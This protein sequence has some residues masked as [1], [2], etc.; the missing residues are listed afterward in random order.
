MS[1]TKKDKDK[2]SKS[3]SKSAKTI[4]SVKVHLPSIRPDEITIQQRLGEGAY[5]EVFKGICRQAPVAV[6]YIKE[7]KY[8]P[9]AL[10]AELTIMFQAT[11]ANIVKI[12]GVLVDDKHRPIGIVT[13]FLE[14]GDLEMLLHPEDG[15]VKQ[16]SL[17]TKIGYAIDICLGMSWLMGKE[18][19]IIHRDLKPAN[20]ML[21]KNQTSC[22]ICDFGLAVTNESKGAKGKPGHVG[23]IKSTR[24]SPL[25]MAPER[26]AI[27]VMGD[28]ELREA[29]AQEVANYTKSVK[30]DKTASN[31]SEK[32][33]VYSFGVMLWEMVTQAW[34][35][36]D[37]L[38][39]ESFTELFSLILSGKRPSLKDIDPA[40]ASIIEKCWQNDPANRPTFDSCIT[41]L[42]GARID[43]ALQS[44]L[45]STAA[46][47]WKKKCGLIDQSVT[48]GRFVDDLDQEGFL[49]SSKKNEQALKP[50]IVE[51]CISCLLGPAGGAP[52]AHDVARNQQISI[53]DFVKLIKWFGPLRGTSTNC[54]HHMV[55]ILQS[56]WFFGTIERQTAERLIHESPGVFLIRLNTG[57]NAAIESS[58]FVISTQLKKEAFHIRVVAPPRPAYGKWFCSGPPPENKKFNAD[59][60]TALI[61]DLTAA[62]IL[63]T[64]V[65]KSPFAPIFGGAQAVGGCYSA[66]LHD[67]GSGF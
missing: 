53:F 17:D 26:V 54:F 9:D 64:P 28:E 49:K 35:F 33:D 10:V 38:T 61:N 60:L 63:S 11:S 42:R 31:S 5:G 20:I 57:G 4:D 50:E 16:I 39:S 13:E 45:C 24:G 2:K 52:V 21:D 19:K 25:W 44:T 43:L 65:P 37:L 51:R 55:A 8:D 7:E 12:Q 58:P 56:P 18:V 46:A 36:V 14:G 15:P 1:T 27:K 29:L 41:M 40:I 62:K 59:D 6:K 48:I 47:F 32:S 66:D 67:F 22:K 3:S 30:I 34:P 23:D